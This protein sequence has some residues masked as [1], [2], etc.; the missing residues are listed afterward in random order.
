MEFA[1]EVSVVS[2]PLWI[3]YQW[4]YLLILAAVFVLQYAKHY[5]FRGNF[6]I[7]QSGSKKL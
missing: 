5:T 7:F 3:W 1:Y 4:E 2:A 6:T